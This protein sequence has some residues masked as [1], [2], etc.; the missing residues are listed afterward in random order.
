MQESIATA[1]RELNETI[2]FC[3]VE[4]FHRRLDRHPLSQRIRDRYNRIESG[5]RDRC[6]NPCVLKLAPA[7]FQLLNLTHHSDHPW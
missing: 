1:V 7:N 5:G 6:P 3:R 4:P 2:A